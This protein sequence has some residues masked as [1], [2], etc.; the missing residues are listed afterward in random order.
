[1]EPA[2]I[3]G[4]VAHC[5]GARFTGILRMRAKEGI[6]E[7]WF[8]S[9]VADEMQ[10]GTSTADEAMDRMRKATEATYELVSRLPHPSGGFKKRFPAKG[11]VATATPV[12]LMR[13]CEQYAL[14]CSLAVESRDVLAIATYELG[15][16]V[17]VETTADDD[18][19]TTMLEAEEGTYEFTLPRVELPAG[20]PVL[21][22]ASSTLME[23]IAPP[24]SLG[25]RALLDAK[26]TAR[27]TSEEEVKRK[28][29]E[30]VR[31]KKPAP[32]PTP[33]APAVEAKPAAPAADEKREAEKREAEKRKAEKLEAEKRK[34]EKLEAEKRE[35]EKREAEKREAEKR[36]TEKR[37]AEKREA[38][39]REAEKPKDE[40]PKEEKP[41][42]P[43]KTDEDADEEKPA[44]DEASDEEPAKAPP[45][46]PAPAPAPSNAALTWG[47][48]LAIA[49]VLAYLFWTSRF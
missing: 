37:E 48:A 8:L 41:A 32:A 43:A 21:P 44:E 6:G 39:K 17:S 7:V 31:H 30:K 11:S 42:E 16:L 3:E 36:E 14:T 13:Y 19:I 29:V 47:I 1:M 24:E 34:A 15:D 25:F 23:S 9:G 20:T 12:T 46:A 5:E 26:P 33:A 45:P 2:S 35:A 27:P 28:T 4:L 22:P 49:V 18:A 38:E 40:K 10:F